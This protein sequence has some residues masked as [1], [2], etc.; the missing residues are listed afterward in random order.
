MH[1]PEQGKLLHAALVDM[2]ITSLVVRRTSLSLGAPEHGLADGQ[3]SQ[4]GVQDLE[5]VQTC[6]S[7]MVDILHSS[8]SSAA[9]LLACPG[10]ELSKHSKAG[11]L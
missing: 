10:T 3:T 8:P 7:G 11:P 6:W 5:W 2:I 9:A 4:H 1:S